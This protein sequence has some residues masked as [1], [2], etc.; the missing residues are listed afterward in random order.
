[1]EKALI[2]KI[3]NHLELDFQALYSNDENLHIVGYEVLSRL[4]NTNTDTRENPPTFL[5]NVK[6][7]HHYILARQ[8]LLQV[9]NIIREMGRYL[10]ER[11]MRLHLNLNPDDLKDEITIGYILMVKDYIVVE[12]IEDS[13]NIKEIIPILIKLKSNGVKIALDDWGDSNA[14][15]NYIIDKSEAYGIFDIVKIDGSLIKDIDIKNHK[16]E[17]ITRVINLMKEH[18]NQKIVMEYVHNE[19]IL[20]IAKQIN[21]DVLQGFYLSEPIREYEFVLELMQKKL[22]KAV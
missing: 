5:K 10:E 11:N 7:K 8:V 6:L 18:G 14:T 4:Y 21:A 17:F 3:H 22:R 16:L 2:Y 15:Y 9:K 1:M 12:I 13:K 20:N 19:S